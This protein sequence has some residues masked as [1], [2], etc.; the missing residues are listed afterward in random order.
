MNNHRSCR[1]RRCVAEDSEEMHAKADG[2]DPGK[3]LPATLSVAEF[4]DEMKK[5]LEAGFEDK[6]M[7]V[8]RD[9]RKDFE[10]MVKKHGTERW[11]N[12]HKTKKP[13]NTKTTKSAGNLLPF[14]KKGFK[15]DC[16]SYHMVECAQTLLSPNVSSCPHFFLPR[17]QPLPLMQYWTHT[18]MNIHADDERTLSHI[19][20]MDETELSHDF[21]DELLETF[22]E[23]IHGIREND[24]YIN[25]WILHHTVQKLLKK[26]PNT[27]MV[28][29]FVAI[30]EKFPNKG[31][32][33]SLYFSYT[34]IRARFDPST[35]VVHAAPYLKAGN[36]NLDWGSMCAEVL[37]SF[38]MLACP[39]C[40]VY[41]CEIHAPDSTEGRFAARKRVRS[42]TTFRCENDCYMNYRA[43]G[44]TNGMADDLSIDIDVETR[45]FPV[46]L[47]AII[48]ILRHSFNDDYCR[49]TR[50]LNKKSK[51][52]YSCKEVQWYCMKSSP[53]SPRTDL[54]SP[55]K[56]K[57]TA[58]QQHRLFRAVK[59]S[60]DQ[61]EVKNKKPYRACH[62]SG[63]CSKDNGCPCV[64][65][66]NLCTKYCGCGVGCKYLFPGCRCAPGNCRTKQCQCFYASW[67]CDPDI[68]KQCQCGG[69]GDNICKN[70]SIQRGIQK[71]LVIAPSQ[72]A[73]WGCFA[74]DPIE[75]NDFIS[76]YCGE[77]ISSQESER[78]GIIYD[79]VKTSYLFGLNDE[80]TVD[81]TRKGN[82]IRFAN[83]SKFPNCRTKVMVVNGDHKI[84]IFACRNIAMGEELF[85][86]YSY[87]KNQI[88]EFV[89]KELS[90]T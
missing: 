51:I 73:G 56:K 64:A 41:D 83:H 45:E 17:V 60:I 3:G 85:F 48:A 21:G 89:P 13:I 33:R 22:E 16:S 12:Y 59:W 75:K 65:A 70:I 79:K 54:M 80:Q 34:D 76:E 20:F 72:V 26:Y 31:S 53:V 30:H 74:A 67:E 71:R 27:K 4:E 87:N 90:R 49:I 23:G 55:H 50:S 25:E 63:P 47:K 28:A 37:N 40:L 24:G 19:P 44:E 5:P 29:I 2:G 81:A 88:V 8:Y 46:K 68:C 66:D 7:A 6:L 43:V 9:V 35:V 84:G 62:H 32:V 11:N 10:A 18:D 1:K 15:R 38:E 57:K 39:R 58:A 82:L 69:E 78:R 36:E 52:E 14:F 86:D 61:G 77:L 42:K